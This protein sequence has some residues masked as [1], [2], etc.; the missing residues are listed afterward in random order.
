MSIHMLNH[1]HAA[2]VIDVNKDERIPWSKVP[3]IV[4]RD[5]ERLRDA[6]SL[7]ELLSKK[8]N[9]A[10]FEPDSSHIEGV[11]RSYDWRREEK[12]KRMQAMSTLKTTTH[13]ALM[14]C[15]RN[16]ERAL[17]MERYVKAL[18]AI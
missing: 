17:V 13:I 5:M 7:C 18:A 15:K 9:L 1:L 8:V 4:R 2:K 10:G 3:K 6:R 16:D 12:A 11:R 14:K